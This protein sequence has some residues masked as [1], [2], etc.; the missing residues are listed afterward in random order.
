[1]L[2]PAVLRRRRASPLIIGGGGT[3][4]I[5]DAVAASTGTAGWFDFSRAATVF[6]DSGATTP[7]TDGAGIQSVVP[8]VGSSP[9]LVT[10]GITNPTFALSDGAADYVGAADTGLRVT[11]SGFAADMYMAMV[12]APDAAQSSFITASFGSADNLGIAVNGDGSAPVSNLGT[13][14][15][16]VDGV[17]VATRDAYY[18]AV[19]DGAKHL[20]EFLGINASA[21][22]FLDMARLNGSFIF[23]GRVYDLVFC[24]TPADTDALAAQ[25]NTKNG[26]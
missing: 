1:M 6:S 10:L 12:I 8:Y 7:A 19:A 20:V 11:S 25:L 14:T 16:K 18:D 22:T 3:T 23:G 24:D 2:S 13:P 26:L 5:E 21:E 9:N 4:D 17:T 15:A